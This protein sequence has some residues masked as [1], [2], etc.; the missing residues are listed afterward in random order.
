MIMPNGGGGW[1]GLKGQ[2]GQGHVM[3]ESARA[4]EDAVPYGKR[5]TSWV[6]CMPGA[7]RQIARC[8]LSVECRVAIGCCV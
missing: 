1:A 7:S 6:L 2:M 4:A 8:F 5:C 3:R